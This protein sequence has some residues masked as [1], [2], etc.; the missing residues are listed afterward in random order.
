MQTYASGRYVQFTSPEEDTTTISFFLY[1]GQS[2]LNVSMALRMVGHITDADLSYQI[3]V[4][5]KATTAMAKNY[6]VPGSFTFGK[7]LPVDSARIVVK[8]SPELLTK[9]YLLA[10]EITSGK[11]LEPGQHT[12]IR[13]I[14][15]INDIISR[16]EWWDDNVEFRNLGTYTDKKFRTFITA[17]GIGDLARY[18]RELYFEFFR[19][20]KYYLIRM[21]DAGT[22]VLEV[23][24]TDMLST[25][26]L[27]G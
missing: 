16:P 6:A 2:E 19:Q 13:K 15:R 3:K 10:L 23:D 5:D 27:K 20:F 26:P 9:S 12:H 22:P 14:I 17:T 8:N 25:V 21:K 11:D 18:P 1:P 24:G 4:D 7:G